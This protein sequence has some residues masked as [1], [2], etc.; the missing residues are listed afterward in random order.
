[1]KL[2]I[3][4]N[5]SL[6]ANCF[7]EFVLF[8]SGLFPVGLKKKKRLLF[9]PGTRYTVNSHRPSELENEGDDSV[10]YNLQFLSS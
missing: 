1:M 4:E 6:W 5:S 7:K 10:T 9:L 3:I 2:I 8:S